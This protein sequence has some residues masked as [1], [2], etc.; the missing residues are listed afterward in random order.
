[1]HVWHDENTILLRKML[2][3]INYY[4]TFLYYKLYDL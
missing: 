4:V 2:H 3:N 1:M